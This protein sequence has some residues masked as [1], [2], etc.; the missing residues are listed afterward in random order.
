M[1]WLVHIFI[2][3]TADVDSEQQR[4]VACVRSD[5]VLHIIMSLLVVYGYHDLGNHMFVVVIVAVVVYVAVAIVV[6]WYDMLIYRV[7]PYMLNTTSVIL[8][9]MCFLLCCHCAVIVSVYC[10]IR[11]CPGVD[12]IICT[13]SFVPVFTLIYMLILLI[14]ILLLFSLLLLSLILLSVICC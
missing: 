8:I 6:I 12:V 14:M 13:V 11:T 5:S 2:M 9:T 10:C 7:C 4:H 1:R 3:Y